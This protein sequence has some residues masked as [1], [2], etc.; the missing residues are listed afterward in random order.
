MIRVSKLGP[1]RDTTGSSILDEYKDF[2]AGVQGV[3]SIDLAQIQKLPSKALELKYQEELDKCTEAYESATVTIKSTLTFEVFRNVRCSPLKAI[4]TQLYAQ[5]GKEKAA[6]NN[7]P[8]YDAAYMLGD[9]ISWGVPSSFF[10]KYQSVRAI[11]YECLMA[12]DENRPMKAQSKSLSF[13]YNFHNWKDTKESANY[14]GTHGLRIIQTTGNQD[15]HTATSLDLTAIGG[16]NIKFTDFRYIPIFAGPWYSSTAYEKFRYFPREPSA[17]PIS[18]FFSQSDGTLKLFPKGLYVATNPVI[19]FSVASSKKDEFKQTLADVANSGMRIFGFG[20]IR[21]HSRHTSVY[22]GNTSS[23]K[24][25]ISISFNDCKPQLF[26][27]DNY[28]NY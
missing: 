15:S 25:E 5:I 23:G 3:S 14:Q 13:S 19:T 27:V 18:R 12:R 21:N 26:A 28:F 9:A 2:L 8:A 1:I 24:T 20:N 7:N 10:K 22:E 6:M 4:Q 11:E 16:V 17:S